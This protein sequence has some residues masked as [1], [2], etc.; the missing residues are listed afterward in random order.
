LPFDKEWRSV[1]IGLRKKPCD[2]RKTF[3]EKE[4]Q[5]KDNFPNYK[6]KF[7]VTGSCRA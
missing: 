7:L 2:Y 4:R 5:R 6:E 3:W 1:A